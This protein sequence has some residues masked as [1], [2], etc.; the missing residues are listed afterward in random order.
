MGR[1]PG[2]WPPGP[3][4]FRAAIHQVPRC[5]WPVVQWFAK[6]DDSRARRISADVHAGRDEPGQRDRSVGDDFRRPLHTFGIFG[7]DPRDLVDRDVQLRHPLLP[8][9]LD[10]FVGF[11]HCHVEPLGPAAPP[12]DCRRQQW[13]AHL[14]APP[15]CSPRYR[16]APRPTAPRG[17]AGIAHAPMVTVK[18]RG[19]DGCACPAL[20]RRWCTIAFRS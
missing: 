1:R 9:S 3:P 2:R 20:R 15:D 11:Q 14:A 17:A 8:A 12:R 6:Q 16:P 13:P 4:G 10:G 18:H 5:P 19:V 7:C